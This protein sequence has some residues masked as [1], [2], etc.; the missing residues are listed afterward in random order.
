MN[1]HRANWIF[2]LPFP[3]ASQIFAQ[4]QQQVFF[5]LLYVKEEYRYSTG[6]RKKSCDSG[7]GLQGPGS[8]TT[9]WE[10]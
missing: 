9:Q 8:Q 6:E 4:Q 3:K 10:H 2:T 1:N 5:P 7:H